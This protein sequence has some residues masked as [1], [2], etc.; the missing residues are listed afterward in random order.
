MVHRVLSL[1][2][3]LVLQQVH[4]VQLVLLVLKV[5]AH[6]MGLGAQEYL[7]PLLVQQV[8]EVLQV[9][10]AQVVLAAPGPLVILR[11]L[12]LPFHRVLPWFLEGQA[13]LVYQMDL[14]VLV[15]LPHHVH[16]C[17]KAQLG[18]QALQV[19]SLQFHLVVQMA[20]S[21]QAVL[22]LP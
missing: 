7:I 22:S 2:L 17:Q 9:Q 21:L 12:T 11:V 3:G 16:L 18:L 15:G 5:Q 1:L 4:L 13:D 19:L 20:L 6:Q 14:Q 8:Q 10:M